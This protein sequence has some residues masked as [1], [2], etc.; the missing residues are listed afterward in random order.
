MFRVPTLFVVGAGASKEAGLPTANELKA[1]IAE[2]VDIRLED[3]I[4]GDRAIFQALDL[5]VRILSSRPGFINDYLLAGMQIR[6]AMPLASS[7][8]NYLDIHQG[9]ERIEICG[10]LG[11]IR[12]ILDAERNSKLFFDDRGP[13]NQKLQQLADTWYVS[14][15]QLLM[16]GCHRNDVGNIFRNVS[17]ITFNYDRCIE[18]YL[19]HAIRV[20]YSISQNDAADRDHLRRYHVLSRKPALDLL[21]SLPLTSQDLSY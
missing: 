3:E 12:S 5:K 8:D 18:H 14:F 7:I 17:F 10:K 6:D 2:R 20:S 16:E 21:G 1:K 9:N 4:H 15:A 11:I 19:F 13:D